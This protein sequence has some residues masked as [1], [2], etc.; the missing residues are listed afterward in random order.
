M[1]KDS[2]KSRGHQLVEPNFVSSGLDF[3][4]ITRLLSYLSKEIY[5]IAAIP[6]GVLFEVI[7]AQF[8]GGPYPSIGLFTERFVDMDANLCHLSDKL[9]DDLNG[10]VNRIGINEL[11]FASMDEQIT[12]EDVLAPHREALLR[13]QFDWSS[14][15]RYQAAQKQRDERN[16]NAL[17][18]FL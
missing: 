13:A 6:S 8:T 14:S 12:W 18:P 11:I 1:A 3:D 15:P 7:P 9:M 5:H 10:Y 17:K 4:T 2:E 16:A